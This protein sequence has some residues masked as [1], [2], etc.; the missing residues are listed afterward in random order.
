MN[1]LCQRARPS[2]VGLPDFIQNAAK[3]VHILVHT[4]MHRADAI[5][6]SCFVFAPLP[7]AH[8]CI[9]P[10]GS[11]FG[12]CCLQCHETNAL[13]PVLNTQ[14]PEAHLQFMWY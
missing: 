5:P 8:L 2:A 3:H 14:S 6:S 11:R 13:E 7:P 9:L 10:D 1:H 4:C 12:L